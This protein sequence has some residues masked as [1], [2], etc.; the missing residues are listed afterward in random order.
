MRTVHRV[1]AVIHESLG[2]YTVSRESKF[3]KIKDFDSQEEAYDFI[4][5]ESSSFEEYIVKEILIR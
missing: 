5:N 1:Y 3:M 2:D 4:F